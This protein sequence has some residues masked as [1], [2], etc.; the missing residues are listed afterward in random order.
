VSAEVDEA[1]PPGP[2]P[3]EPVSVTVTPMV[4]GESVESALV[5]VQV[6]EV[7]VQ[8]EEAL[9]WAGRTHE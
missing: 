9:T 8:P 5:T 3:R 4:Y 7:E 1:D 2:E 6:T